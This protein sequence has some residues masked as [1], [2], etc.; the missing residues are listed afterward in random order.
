M[1]LRIG[2]DDDGATVTGRPRRFGELPSGIAA[3]VCG[4]L[5]AIFLPVFLVNPV[6]GFSA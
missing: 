2:V 5:H 1:E 3:L 4:T 6:C